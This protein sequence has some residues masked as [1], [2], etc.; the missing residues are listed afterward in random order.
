MG[1]GSREN[2][3]IVKFN[4]ILFLKTEAAKFK[5]EPSEYITVT[6]YE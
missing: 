6:F 1:F 4:T 2:K 5:V 3:Y